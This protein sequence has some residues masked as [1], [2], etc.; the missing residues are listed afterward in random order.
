MTLPPATPPHPF[1]PSEL[2]ELRGHGIVLWA[3]RVVFEAQPPME[4]DAIAAVQACCAGPLPTALVQL[5]QATAGGSLDY[6]LVLPMETAEGEHMEA[7]SWSELF[8]TGSSGYR[9]LQ[10]WIEHEI[11]CAQEAADEHGR[12]FNGKLDYLP[13]GGF[14]YCD[15]IYATVTPPGTSDSGSV[16]AWKKGLPPAWKGALHE[17]GLATLAPDLPGAFAAL[18]L[19]ED[20]LAPTSRYHAGQSLLE[21][22]EVRTTDH[23]MPRA[24]ADRLLAHYRQALVDWRTPLAH[25]TLAR[26]PASARVALLHAI[27]ADDAALLQRLAAAGVPMAGALQGSATALDLALERGKPHTADVL[28]R[29]LD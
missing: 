17:D 11:E 10:G 22:L 5:W 7:I 14:E 18:C 9:D 29:L 1:T 13:F 12:A 2:A 3:G 27:E 16:L 15:R 26:S 6:D 25:G 8:W 23:G 28:K 20:P 21:A 24:L 4:A 19:H